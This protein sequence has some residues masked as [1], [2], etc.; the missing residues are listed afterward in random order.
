MVEKWTYKEKEIYVLFTDRSISLNQ[1]GFK[2]SAF[3]VNQPLL[4]PHD[5][6][7]SL[8]NGMEVGR[9]SLNKTFDKFAIRISYSNYNKMGSLQS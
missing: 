2:R 7:E 8:D 1:S 9:V 5:F 6:C 4:N 3:C